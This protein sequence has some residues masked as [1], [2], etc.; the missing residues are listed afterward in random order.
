MDAVLTPLWW[1][2]EVRYFGDEDYEKGGTLCEVTVHVGVPGEKPLFSRTSRGG[3]NQ[4]STLG[5]RYKGSY[6]NA[7]KRAFAAVGPGHEVY[8]GAADLDPD[9]NEDAANQQGRAETPADARLTEPQRQRV[10]AAFA[11]AGVP[12]EEIVLFLRAVGLDKPEDMQLS[13]AVQLR[14]LLDARLK[15]VAA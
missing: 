2:E 10:L 6:T 7:A 14:E 5:N 4:A 11:E 8:L 12:D 1:W 13:H 3:V 15:E 9:T